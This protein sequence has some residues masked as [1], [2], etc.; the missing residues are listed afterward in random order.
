MPGPAPASQPTVTD[1]EIAQGQRRGRRHTAPQVQVYRAP[2]A[3][4]WPAPPTLDQGSAGT[5][6]G[7]HEHW[8]RA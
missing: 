8:A 6:L 3:R 1:D 5:H 4:L 2:L 7:H